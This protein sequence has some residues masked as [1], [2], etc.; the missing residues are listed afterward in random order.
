MVMIRGHSIITCTPSDLYRVVRPW[1]D[2]IYVKTLKEA[3]TVA[4]SSIGGG[5]VHN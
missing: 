4:D 1:E 2:T 5:N 3:L